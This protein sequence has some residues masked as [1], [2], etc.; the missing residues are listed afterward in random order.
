MQHSYPTLTFEPLF[1]STPSASH[2]YLMFL[3][4]SLHLLLP[5]PPLTPSWFF[6]G[7]LGISEPGALNIYTFFRFIPST[8]FVSRNLIFSHFPLSGSLNSLLCDLIAPTA[9]LAF[10]L[11]M[12]RTLAAASSLSSQCFSF[13]ELSIFSLSSFDLYCD[14]VG[15]NISP[16]KASLLSFL[17]VYAP[18]I[19]SFPT[20]GRTNFF[21]PSI[22]PPPE[23]YSFL[24]TSIAITPSGTQKI[25]STPWGGSIRLAHIF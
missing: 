25:L 5:L 11:L 19:C 24:G 16:N 9:G 21:S 17:N 7:I 8:F 15:V 3:A 10:F 18:P 1:V 22:F 2:H 13:S 23:I 12:P 14:Y 20:D 4:V 6:N